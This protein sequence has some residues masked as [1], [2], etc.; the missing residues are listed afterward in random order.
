MSDLNPK[1]VYQAYKDD[2]K[3]GPLHRPLFL[4]RILAISVACLGAI[5]TGYNLYQSWSH[6]IPYGQ[7]SHRLDQYS[8]WVKNFECKIEYR[9]VSTGQGT[10]VDVG[11]CPKS[12]ASIASSRYFSA[13]R[14]PRKSV[15]PRSNSCPTINATCPTS[16]KPSARF[17]PGPRG[18]ECS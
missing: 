11:A 5:P 12:N 9:T 8:L 17:K 10:K 16:P 14:S 3:S 7:V 18:C 15:M 4:A 6:G 1:A 13:E 2:Q